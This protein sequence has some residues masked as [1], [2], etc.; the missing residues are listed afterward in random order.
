MGDHVLCLSNEVHR[1][2]P[3]VLSTSEIESLEE[4]GAQ[5]DK[6][7]RVR[8]VQEEGVVVDYL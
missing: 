8:N 2:H 6:Y 4:E 7:V 3:Y 1:F 5:A